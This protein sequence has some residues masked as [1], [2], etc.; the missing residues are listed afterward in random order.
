[1]SDPQQPQ[2]PWQTPEPPTGGVPPVAPAPGFGAP[3]PPSGGVPPVPPAP[4]NNSPQPPAPGY[5]PP[6]P[7]YAAPAP[8]YS[9]PTPGY[10]A[11][12]GAYSP[13]PAMGTP[14]YGAPVAQ[15]YGVAPAAPV[16]RSNVLG[17]VA[18]VA[19]L[20]VLIVV[21]ILTYGPAHAI[22]AFIGQ[23]AIALALDNSDDLSVLAPVRGDVL[24]AE[25]WFWVG[26]L[27][28]IAALVLGIVAI[29]KR[30]G[31]GMGITAIILSVL[32]P[33]GYFLVLMIGVGFG[34]VAALM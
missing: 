11:P 32:A 29:A 6:K 20:F 13:P 4:G 8:G 22:G 2:Y 3:V 28:G 10:S 9:A 19:S 26:T 12:T 23:P 7:G 31:R 18:L 17:I 27:V 14:P 34:A 24:M 1:M 21:P 15:T 33:I 25:V 16:K 30:A 5:S